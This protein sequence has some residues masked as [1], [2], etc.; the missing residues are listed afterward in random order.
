[1]VVMALM[2]IECRLVIVQVARLADGSKENDGDAI[3]ATATAATTDS[4]HVA[5]SLFVCICC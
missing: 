3:S 2:H 5:G 4:A 1:M